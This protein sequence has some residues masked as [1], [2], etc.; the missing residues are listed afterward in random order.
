MISSI[1][2]HIPPAFVLLMGAVLLLLVRGSVRNLLAVLIPIFTFFF[3]YE[4]PT[5][6]S[7]SVP[8]MDQSLQF[9]RV[10][11]LSKIFAYIFTISL[12][13]AFLYGFYIKKP[14]EFLAGLLYVGCAL[15]V[16][17]AGDMVVLYIFLGVD[18]DYFCLIDSCS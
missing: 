9:L 16:V 13:V 17:F 1:L 8:F 5:N 10:D 12:T 11:A 18:G 6:A 3:I 15:G 14:F 4:L 7:F 2:G